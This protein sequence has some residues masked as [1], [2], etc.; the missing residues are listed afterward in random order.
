MLRKVGFRVM[1]DIYLRIAQKALELRDLT[2][3]SAKD[4]GEIEQLPENP[5]D[6]K[7][8]KNLGKS[9]ELLG[10]LFEILDELDVIEGRGVQR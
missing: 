3:A 6:S 5:N 1:S 8:F 7:L 4:A 9:S 2:F 10:E